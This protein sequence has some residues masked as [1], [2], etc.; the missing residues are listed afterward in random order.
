M[1]KG[2][3]IKAVS[4]RRNGD[5]KTQPLDCGKGCVPSKDPLAWAAGLEVNRPAPTWLDDLDDTLMMIFCV[6]L[7]LS[8]CR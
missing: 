1:D 4:L 3:E 6:L 7:S 2:R 5:K 8:Q